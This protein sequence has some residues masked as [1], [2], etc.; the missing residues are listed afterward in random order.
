M[1]T[2]ITLPSRSIGTLA[3]SVFPL[4]RHGF[5]LSDIRLSRLQIVDL[6]CMSVYNRSPSGGPP[7]ELSN[8]LAHV[9]RDR[10]KCAAS[11]DTSPSTRLTASSTASH[12]LA[13]F[14]A[15]AS[16][17]GWRYP[18][19]TRDHA[20]NLA[21]RGLLLRSLVNF[22]RPLGVVFFLSVWTPRSWRNAP[23]PVVFRR[24][25]GSAIH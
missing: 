8:H 14:S 16:R 1:I 24:F 15:V 25:F 23:P 4:L 18:R 19:R 12:N 10:S 20:Q 22:L 2:P 3:P 17:I 7:I 21:R 11:R 9:H 13:A 6:Y 5:E